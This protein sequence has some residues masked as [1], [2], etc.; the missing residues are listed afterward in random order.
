MTTQHRET[1]AY[2]HTSSGIRTHTRYLS[3]PG[4]YAV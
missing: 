2:T 1:R 3:G 4:L